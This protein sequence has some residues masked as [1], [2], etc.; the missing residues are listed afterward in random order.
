MSGG[1]WTQG[2]FHCSKCLKEEKKYVYKKRREMQALTV[3]RVMI[4]KYRREGL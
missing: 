3:C 1:R 2:A 4:G